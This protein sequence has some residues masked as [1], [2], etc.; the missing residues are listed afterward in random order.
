M[1]QWQVA[2]GAGKKETPPIIGRDE[3]KL[4]N[5]GGFK[6]K[7]PQQDVVLWLGV[8]AGVDGSVFLALG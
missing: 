7:L 5:K 3:S 6:N 1:G 4:F 2:S 8:Q